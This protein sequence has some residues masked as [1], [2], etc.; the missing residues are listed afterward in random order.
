LERT[1]AGGVV[2]AGGAG[3]VAWIAWKVV[4]HQLRHTIMVERAYISGGGGSLIEEPNLFVLTVQNYGKTSG[5]VTAYALFVCDRADLPP[6]P[7]YLAPEYIPTPFIATYSPEG[8]TQKITEAAIPPSAPNPIAYGRLWYR[9][10]WGSGKY[11][12]SF[13]LPLQTPDDHTD[14]VSISEAY[15]SST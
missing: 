3:F 11:H 15:T 2:G 4:Q 6:E 14:L 7:A 13:I 12:F 1:L 8:K 9:D 10:A 5:T